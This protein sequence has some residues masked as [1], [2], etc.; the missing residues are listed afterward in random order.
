M[1]Y[2]CDLLDALKGHTY[3]D[4]VPSY[5]S[6]LAPSA[7]RVYGESMAQLA[8]A[9]LAVTTDFTTEIHPASL[10]GA[11][12]VGFT[13]EGVDEGQLAQ[14]SAALVH[15]EMIGDLLRPLSL[16]SVLLLDDDLLTIQKYQG[17][18]NE[19]FTR[20]LVHLTCSQV[21]RSGRLTILDPMAGRGTTL[22]AAWLVGHDAYG[23][24]A[25]PNSVAAAAA[26][27]KTYLRTKKIKHSAE[28]S[29]LRAHGKKLGRMLTVTARLGAATK[30]NPASDLPTL[31][32]RLAQGDARQVHDLF[33]KQKFDAI[34]TDAPYGVVHRAAAG[35]GT[36]GATEWARSP[37]ELFTVALPAWAAAL[38]TGGALGI[39]W[40]RLTLPRRELVAA[41]S[42][43][44]LLV[45]DEGAW[46]DFGHRVDS[47]IHRDVL[48]AVKKP[49]G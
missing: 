15:F 31:N 24:E 25:E 28:L 42:A 47:S 45:C 13:A 27:L 19:A 22:L 11:P 9:E 5:L 1:P 48:V 35:P 16:P 49:R 32:L 20:L 37:R 39:G 38:R 36:V 41:V 10:A 30:D 8:A 7:N 3:T 12:A 21:Q 44:G 14:Q 23:I 2:R 4:W 46:L 6:L 18:T 33:G 34:I 43:A 40:N 29:T 17:K 26:F